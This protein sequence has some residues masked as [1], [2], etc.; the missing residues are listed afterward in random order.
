MFV[1][2][3]RHDHCVTDSAQVVRFAS[4]TDLGEYRELQ[5]D[6]DM[7]EVWYF[8]PKAS[9]DGVSQKRFDSSR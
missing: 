8:E 3:F 7:T 4:V 1:A 2:T 5:A 6:P 9:L